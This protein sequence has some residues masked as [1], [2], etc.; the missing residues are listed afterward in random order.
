[1]YKSFLVAAVLLWSLSSWA[2]VEVN[3]ASEA[4]LDGVKGLGPSSTARILVARKQ[5]PF[6]DWR[7]F[8]HRVAGIKGASA[9]KLSA[10]G[11]TVNGESFVQEAA[12]VPP[13]APK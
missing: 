7:D 12:P 5:G 2:A 11:L 13:A 4:E 1:M 9:A 10:N 6:K 3:T 8:L